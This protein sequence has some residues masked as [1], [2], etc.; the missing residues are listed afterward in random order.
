MS[1]TFAATE[2][3]FVTG[4]WEPFSSKSL[5]NKGIATELITIICKEAGI[6][7]TFNF[8]PWPR[9]EVAIEEGTAFAAFPYALT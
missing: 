7:P 9:A 8:V 2:V 1:S 6:N 5:P 4:E 3:V